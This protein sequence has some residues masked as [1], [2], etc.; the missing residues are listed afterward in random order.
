MV[1]NT[2]FVALH[3]AIFSVTLLVP[4]SLSPN[5]IFSSF[6]NYLQSLLFCLAYRPD[7]HQTK[8]WVKYSLIFEISVERHYDGRL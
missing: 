7:T 2:D 3:Y 5:I 6:F 4:L 8:Q 1:K